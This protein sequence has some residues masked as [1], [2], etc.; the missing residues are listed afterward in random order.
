MGG[1]DH[2]AHGRGT[3]DALDGGGL[4]AAAEVE[5]LLLQPQQQP[6]RACD[7]AEMLANIY[8]AMVEKM[9]KFDLRNFGMLAKEMSANADPLR[10]KTYHQIILVKNKTG[11]RNLYQLISDSYLKYY[12]RFPRIPKTKLQQHREGLI[13]GSGDGM[14]HTVDGEKAD[15][16]VNQ[17]YWALYLN[18]EY[19]MAGIYDTDIT[20]G[21]AYK[22]EYTIG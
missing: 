4:Q 19:A 12:K 5:D 7:D 14:F 15:W 18:G 6:G 22:L 16:S 2:G 1:D 9:H 11:L 10:L 8:F 21:T 3:Q 17:S 20:D 13:I